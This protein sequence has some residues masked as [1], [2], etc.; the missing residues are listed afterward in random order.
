[1]AILD[2]LLEGY[3]LVCTRCGNRLKVVPQVTEPPPC[4]Q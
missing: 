4:F 2:V 1:M 3:E